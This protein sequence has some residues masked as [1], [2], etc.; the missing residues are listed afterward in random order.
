M[1]FKNKHIFLSLMPSPNRTI[2]NFMLRKSIILHVIFVMIFGIA[3]AQKKEYLD[4]LS[5]KAYAYLDEYNYRLSIE[6]ANKLIT[7]AKKLDNQY[8]ISKG[9]NI[10]AQNNEMVYDTAAA[11]SN[12][13]KALYHALKTDNKA[14]LAGAYNNLANLYS[15]NK[16]HSHKA[17][18]HYQLS[19]K[20]AKEL[21]DTADMLTPV[22]N[23]GWTHVDNKEYNK[24]LPYLQKAKRFIEKKGDVSAKI[25]IEYLLGAYYEGINNFNLAEQHYLN[26]LKIGDTTK[27]YRDLSNVYYNLSMLQKKTNRHKE[28]LDNFIVYDSLTEMSYEQEKIKEATLANVKFSAEEYKRELAIAKEANELSEKITQKTKQFAYL[29]TFVVAVLLI[30]VIVLYKNQE[31]RS[32]LTKA[33]KNRNERL[34]LATQKAKALAEVKTKFLSTI[35]HELRT[36]LYGIVG[37]TNILLDDKNISQSS[38]EHLTSLKFSGDYLINLINDVLQLSKIESNKVKLQHVSFNVRELLN[39]IKLSFKHQLKRNNNKIHIAVDDSIPQFLLGDPVRLSQI[40]INLVGNA[41][42]F[43]ENGNV[44]LTL[45]TNK[46]GDNEVEILFVV[47]DDGVGIPIEMQC[48]IFESFTQ[49]NRKEGE[50]QGTGLGLSIVQKLIEKF[51]SKIYLE[52]QEGEGAKFSFSIV[53]DI[54]KNPMVKPQETSKN[55]AFNKQH[56]LVVEDNRINQIVT[57]KILEKEG[58]LVSIA[59]NGEEGVNLAQQQEFNLILMDLNM[60]KMDGY[61]ASKTIREFNDAIPIIALTAVEFS[62]VLTKTKESGINDVVVKPY[63]EKEFFQII[64]KHLKTTVSVNS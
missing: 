14:L 54:D 35:S 36:P 59:N 40:L 50:Y 29:A 23:I 37:I 16:K 33:L 41:V 25:Q 47:K 5:T 56:I 63:D 24:A 45:H 9:Y 38:K 11:R 21:N 27:F 4:S 18:E 22:L 39:N 55:P 62:E 60:P 2:I 8:Y 43:T 17:I 1:F 51:N 6:T 64:Y 28:A 52:S 3:N 15:Y 31:S 61:Q 58:F 46:I 7:A 13:N 12:Y 32:R 34:Q 30:L 44:W 53:F 26:A 10:V 42:K 20:Y 19:Y 49:L 57:K 48:K